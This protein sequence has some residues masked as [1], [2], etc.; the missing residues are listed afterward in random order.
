MAEP[1]D[2]DT[3]PNSGRRGVWIIGIVTGIIGSALWALFFAPI[4]TAVSGAVV[5]AIGLF[6]KGYVDRTFSQAA[7]NPGDSTIFLIFFML[8]AILTAASFLLVALRFPGAAQRRLR[9]RL[10]PRMVGGILVILGSIELFLCVVI[11][12]G[13][14]VSIQ[15]NAVFQ[16]RLMALSP[17]LTDQ[18]RKELLRSWAMMKTMSDY[19]LISCE[20]EK[21]AMKYHLDLPDTANLDDCRTQQESDWLLKR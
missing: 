21:L 13:P 4:T 11:L 19:Y 17:A 12:A 16:R 1:P 8:I 7:S 3:P 10:P 14:A 20:T 6:Y 15:A 18:E 9:A 5:S 2:Q